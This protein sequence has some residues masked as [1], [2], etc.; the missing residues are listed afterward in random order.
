MS[1]KTVVNHKPTELRHEGTRDGIAV[2]SSASKS[3]GGRNWTYVDVA[4]REV[5]CE[6][7]GAKS[8]KVCWHLD[9]V[10]TA[11]TMTTV[12]SFVATLSDAAL[13]EVG[14]AAAAVV[15]AGTATVTD[16][17]VMWEC[18][19]SWCD[20]QRARREVAALLAQMPTTEALAARREMAV[21]A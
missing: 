6:C 3:T 12:A 8:G 14:Q 15:E 9:W 4:T 7:Q 18:R 16:H 13:L 5:S 20:R 17:A 11:L 19:R 1:A 2:F 10:L 21:A